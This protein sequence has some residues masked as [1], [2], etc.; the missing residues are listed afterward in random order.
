MEKKKKKRKK[1]S[2]QVRGAPDI[3]VNEWELFET[4]CKVYFIWI[5]R[6]FR[7][8]N[9]KNAFWKRIDLWYLLPLY[10]FNFAY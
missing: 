8:P 7:N 10:K 9:S 4:V 1:N 5:M 3:Q 2:H 6:I